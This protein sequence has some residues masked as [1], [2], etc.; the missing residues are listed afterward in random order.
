MKRWLL[1]ALVSTVA[2]PGVPADEPAHADKT[3][4]CLAP[5]NRI[6]GPRSED[7][8]LP[9]LAGSPAHGFRP[10]CSVLWSALSPNNQPLRI[11]GCFQGGLLQVANDVACGADTGPLWVS[12]RWVVTSADK[13]RTPSRAATC[14]HLETGALA[15]TREFGCVQEKKDLAPKPEPIQ[16]APANS[17][18]S[19]SP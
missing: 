2:S 17:H 5:D 16:R 8:P 11:V 14:Q 7:R 19:P 1:V 9:L 4:V 10:A 12:T 15:A 6:L 18:P 3:G 13:Q